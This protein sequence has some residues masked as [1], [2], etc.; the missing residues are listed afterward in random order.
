MLQRLLGVFYFRLLVGRVIFLHELF[1][2]VCVFR[3]GTYHA[4]KFN[5]I[6]GK[7]YLVAQETGT[8]AFRVEV[9]VIMPFAG[10]KARPELVDGH[11][12]PSF[13]NEEAGML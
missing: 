6:P 12:F 3:Y 1:L 13:A 4:Q 11:V 8:R 7:I 2:V 10:Y 9:V 5:I